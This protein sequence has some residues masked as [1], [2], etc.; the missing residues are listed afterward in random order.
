MKAVTKSV[1]T[2]LPEVSMGWYNSVCFSKYVR[3]NDPPATLWQRFFL[4]L[5][6]FLYRPVLA[7]WIIQKAQ[8]N[9]WLNCCIPLKFG[10]W[11]KHHLAL[12]SL[13]SCRF[14]SK[15]GERESLEQKP[16]LTVK[17]FLWGETAPQLLTCCT[18]CQWAATKPCPK[19]TGRRRSADFFSLVCR[20]SF[21]H[22]T[23][24][25]YTQKIRINEVHLGICSA[26][27]QRTVSR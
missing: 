22:T 21:S 9:A 3:N 7:C 20:S 18:S 27:E 25:T 23:N 2:L 19:G 11:I 17:G 16:S 8:A 14:W 26:Q 12:D 4:L 24:R 10:S 6:V 1:T 5:A 15:A 13:G